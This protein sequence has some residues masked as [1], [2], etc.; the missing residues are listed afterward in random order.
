MH[1]DCTNIHPKKTG[2][3]VDIRFFGN[4]STICLRKVRVMEYHSHI[5]QDARRTILVMVTT[6]NLRL[7]ILVN[8]GFM[9]L[10]I[11]DLNLSKLLR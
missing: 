7:K 8:R 6:A 2:E 11:C 9:S 10:Y 1:G 4:R 3:N 5:H